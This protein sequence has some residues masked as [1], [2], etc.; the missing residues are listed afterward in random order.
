MVVAR[1]NFQPWV[2]VLGELGMAK[3][4]VEVDLAK[5]KYVDLP[6]ADA[7]KLLEAM[8]EV[9]GRRTQ[10]LNEALRYIRNFEEFYEYMRKKFKDFIAPPK[11]PEDFIKGTVI[12]D[13]VKLYKTEGGE[14]RVVIVFDRRVDVEKIKEAL[15]NIGYEDVEVKKSL[16]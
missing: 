5:Y 4:V 12:V 8:A 14:K 2:L 7:E 10:D 9:L 1:A 16:F 13:K 6:A 11:R 3:A 15:K